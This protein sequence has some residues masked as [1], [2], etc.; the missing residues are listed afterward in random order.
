MTQASWNFQKSLPCRSGEREAI[1]S[2]QAVKLLQGSW[3]TYN[4]SSDPKFL[5]GGFGIMV[6]MGAYGLITNQ[7]KK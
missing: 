6:H 2:T 5:G 4:L 3:S 1:S 7:N